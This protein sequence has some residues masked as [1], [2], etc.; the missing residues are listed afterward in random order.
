MYLNEEIYRLKEVVKK[1]Y[2]LE[3]L[4]NDSIMKEKMGKLAALLESFST[5]PIDKDMLQSILKVQLVVKEVQ[6]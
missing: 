2:G 1:S 4:K 6:S 3:E 5:K